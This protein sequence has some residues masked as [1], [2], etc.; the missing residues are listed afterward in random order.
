MLVLF[1]LTGL[2]IAGL[3]PLVADAIDAPREIV[4]VARDMT[5]YL[6]GQ[7]QPNPTIRVTAGEEV[8]VV[9]R[10]EEAGLI[11]DFAV[12]RWRVA[13]APLSEN[14]TGTVVFRAPARPGRYPYVCT[15]HSEMM[16]GILEVIRE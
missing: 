3:L 4:L 13:V 5:F 8:R 14:E 16:R 11:H 9:L 1:G 10:N 15:P 7:A 6:E 12:E 2:A